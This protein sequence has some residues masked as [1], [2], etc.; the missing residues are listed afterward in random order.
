MKR[1]YQLMDKIR[2]SQIESTVHNNSE[3]SQDNHVILGAKTSS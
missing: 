1:L 2:Q 3:N